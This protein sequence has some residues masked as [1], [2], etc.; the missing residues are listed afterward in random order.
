VAVAAVAAVVFMLP[1]TAAQA[2]PAKAGPAAPLPLPAEKPVP[3]H[4]VASHPEKL[5]QP[6]L[7]QKPK[8][9]WPAAGTATAMPKSGSGKTGAAAPTAGSARAGSLPVWIGHAAKGGAAPA[10]GVQVTMA[11]QSAA[12]A[13][14]VRGVLFSVKAAKPSPSGRVHVSLD[15]SAFIDGYGGDFGSRLKLVEL[16]ACALTTPQVAACR[17]QTPVSSVNDPADARVG[18]DVTVPA[19]VPSVTPAIA[20]APDPGLVL[21]ATSTTAGTDGSYSATPLSEAGSWSAGNQS[22]AFE[23]SYPISTPSVPGGLEPQVSLD[24]NSQTVDGLTSSTN[25]QSSWIGDG[26]AYSPGYIERDYSSCETEPP[27][28]SG[29]TASGD[30]CWSSDDETTLDFDGTNTTLVDDPSNGW[31]EETDNGDRVQYLTGADNGCT[32]GGYWVVTTPDGD[33]YYFGENDLPGYASGDKQTASAWNVPVHYYNSGTPCGTA[34]HCN[35]PWRWNLDYVTDSH[36]DAMALFYSDETNYYAEDNATTAGAA[37][38]Y[39]R[40]GV[41]SQIE[42]GLRAGDIYGS[43]AGTLATPAAEVTFTST[44]TRTDVPSDL[45]CTS[46]A[47][48]DVISPTFWSKEQLTTISTSVLEGSTL[49]PVDSWALTQDYPATGD[50]SADPAMWLESIQRTGE[51]GSTP[52]KLPAVTFTPIPL[53]NR[54][55]TAADLNDGYSIIERMRIAQI[56]DETGGLTQVSYDTPPSSCTSGNFP[57]EDDNTTLCYPD[58]WTPPGASSP[59]EDWFN[60]YVVS[61]VTEDNNKI[62]GTIPVTTNYTYSGAAWHYDDDALT[63]SSQRTWDQWRGFRT[64]TAETGNAADGDPVTKTTD[65]YFQGMNGDYQGSGHATTSAS[66]TSSVGS[67]TVTDSDQFQGMDFEHTVYDGAG[68]S[69]VTDTV[70]T[71]WTSSATATQ[72]Q[73]SPLPSLTAYLTGTAKTQTFTGLASGGYREADETYGHDSYARVTWESDVPDASDDGSGGDPSEDTCTQTTYATNRSEWLLDL[74]AEAVV[75]NEPPADCPLSGAPSQSSLLSDTQTLYDGATSVTSD[76]PTAGNSTETLKATGWNGGSEVF[77]PQTEGTFDEYGRALTA[78]NADAIADGYN[79]TT[80]AYTPATGAEPTAETVTDP[81]GLVTTTTYDPARDLPLTVTSPAGDVTTEQYDALGRLTAEWSPGHLISGPADKTFSYTVSDTAPSVVTTNTLGPNGNYLTSE[82]LYDSLGRQVET[83]D[84]TTTGGID[85]TDTF[86]N[87][88]G[89]VQITSNPYYADQAPSTTLVEAADGAV[90][91]QTGYVYDGDGRTVRQITYSYGTEKWETDTSYGGDWTTV[92]PP[93]GGTATTTYVNGLGKTSYEYQYHSATPPAPGSGSQSG[94][95]GWDQTAYTYD[96]DSDLTGITDSAGSQWSYS[97]DLSGNQVSATTPDTGTTTATFD[98]DGNQL[99][100]TDSRGDTTSW[101]YDAD[102]RKTYEYDTT[103][104]ALESGA[105]QRAEWVYDTL[106]KGQL[107]ESVST[108]TG[109]SGNSYAEEA[110]GYNSLGLPK[111]ETVKVTGGTFAGSYTDSYGYTIYADKQ[112]TD[113]YSSAAGLPGE[114]VTTGYDDAGDPVSMGGLWDYVANLSY[115]EL[116]QP[117][118]YTLGTTDNPV[119]VIDS[120]DPVT[121]ALDST[122][123]TAG[124]AATAVDATSYGYSND[125][126]VTSVSDSESGGAATQDQCFQYDYLGRL[127]QAWSQGTSS[128]SSGPSQAAESGAAAPYWE[129]FSYDSENNLTR[130]VSTPAS[131]DATTVTSSFASG[132]HQVSSQ[133]SQTG[134]SGTASQT[135]YEWDAAGD[136]KS[137]AGP[138]GSESLTWGDDGSL[139]SVTDTGGA[140]P[141]TTSDYY[142]ADG[143]L[144]EQDGPSGK[145]LFLPWEELQVSSAGKASGTRFYSIGGTEIAARTSAGDISYLLGDQEGTST[146]SID[147]STLDATRRYYDPYGNSIGAAASSWPGL[148]GFQNGTVDQ[149]TGLENIGAREYDPAAAVFTSPDPVLTPADPQDLNPYA[150]AQDSAPSSEDPSGQCAAAPGRLCAGGQGSPAIPPPSGSKGTVSRG[151]YPLVGVP[152][153]GHVGTGNSDGTGSSEETSVAQISP[154]VYAPS[155]LRIVPVLK[156][157]W[158][159]IV[160]EYPHSDE[161]SNWIRLCIFYRSLCN[162]QWGTNFTSPLQPNYNVEALFNSGASVLLGSG[163]KVA[164][165]IF[166]SGMFKRIFGKSAGGSDGG[167]ELNAEVGDLR[168]LVSDGSSRPDAQARVSSMTDAELLRSAQET[169]VQRDIMFVYDGENTIGNGNHR[170]REILNRLDNPE[171]Q[172][173]PGTI[174]EE[175]PIYVQ[176]IEDAPGVGGE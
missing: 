47:S 73:P 85:V 90:P 94:A 36:G 173:N 110:T 4:A 3:V 83:Q 155:S 42:Y 143:T 125:G 151:P 19:T 27:G 122:G 34:T 46:G 165:I 140:S 67:V 8:T 119:N 21:A 147:S 139:S 23:Y 33:S 146:L 158:K 134:S 57:A 163:A 60:K 142:D 68:G 116:G 41:L 135:T 174:T 28:A 137:I 100:E 148:Q 136:M 88:D 9:T 82:T 111:G 77:T 43:T 80:T 144:I 133:T 123:T 176:N 120:Y 32:D 61:S 31:H 38:E 152:V 48:C 81:M 15:Y 51:D 44:L 121:G 129:Q 18:A 126:Q 10:T 108:P 166:P 113:V 64:V 72:S 175:S 118:E 105:T 128:C 2:A 78:K 5:A 149:D 130:E 87:S 16:P 76:T 71:P 70:T 112:D 66:L 138:S 98:Q 91:S 164:G 37:S 29:W 157:A 102:D 115:T 6:K 49:T 92:T 99:S 11:P 7:W 86:Y 75:T 107:T 172:T 145:T 52:V 62:G 26:W 109:T 171:L 74:P 13:A 65:T 54:V 53:A 127:S 50:G 106:A 35:L 20:A 45:S 79:A 103:G 69:V 59:V 156:I 84:E 17:K 167:V 63:R 39:E 89:T 1:V 160:R 141:G 124:T 30:L 114:E 159:T 24:Y 93:A 170:I 97:F 169:V 55:E 58:Y 132:T 22:G 154:H 12:T 131:G 161:F 95:S 25:N 150:Y 104:G 40:G 117:E 96:A 168:N 14:G 153:A 162:G 56:T 101:T